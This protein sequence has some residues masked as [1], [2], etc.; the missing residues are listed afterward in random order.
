M[1]NPDSLALLHH[2]INQG[3]ARLQRSLLRCSL[4]LIKFHLKLTFQYTS[5]GISYVRGF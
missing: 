3:L 4:I 1:V 2:L 5:S